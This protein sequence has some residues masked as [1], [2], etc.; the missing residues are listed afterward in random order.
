MI[1]EQGIEHVKNLSDT[2]AEL[3]P[4]GVIY[5]TSD[6]S[7]FTWRKASQAF[8]LNIFQVGEPLNAKSVTGRAIQENKTLIENVPRS[9]YGL[10]LKIV[11][12]PIISDAG[13]PV[14][15]FTMVFPLEH[16]I[17]KAFNEF[18]P[19]L[20]DMFPGGAIVY[21]TD[22]TK[23]A[24]VA[25]SEA[26]TLPGIQKGENIKENTPPAEV[27]KTKKGIT[28]EY[29]AEAFG[30]P[31]QTAVRPLFNDETGE[32]V[33]TFGIVIPKVTAAKLRDMS[34]NMEQSLTEIASTVEELA[35]SASEIHASEQKLNESIDAITTFTKQIKEASAFIKEVS[36]QTHLLGLNAAIEA[37][38]AGEAGRGFNVV[39]DEIRKLSGQSKET[40]PKIQKLTDEIAAAVQRSNRMSKQSLS[41]SEE[42]A[43][44]SEE[45]SASLQEIASMSKE[46]QHISLQV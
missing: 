4:G 45:I 23:F 31:V 34:K 46:L 10:R 6:R 40:V 13:E 44:A 16:S 36:D 29:G 26:F 27:I 7:V 33:A 12:Q 41:A 11:A 1:L 38:R 15:A 30:V 5:L 18:A 42:Q 2:Q 8:D 32:L 22:L 3:I 21:A 24:A 14:G 39:A 43:A 9:L 20:K 37:A 25:H 19:V 17:F 28:R 35:A